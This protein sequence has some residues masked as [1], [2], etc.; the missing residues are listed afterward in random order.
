M[1][2]EK[3]IIYKNK[4]DKKT[5]QGLNI[6]ELINDDTLDLFFKLL[7]GYY[8]IL[9]NEIEDHDFTAAQRTLM[10]FNILYGE[11]TTGGFLELIKNQYCNYIFESIF[12]ET[13]KKWGAIELATII[14]QAREIYISKK[15][16]LETTRS[17]HEIFEMYQYFPEFNAL[18]NEF[19][20]VMNSQADKIKRYIQHHIDEFA[21]V[22]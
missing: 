13:L 22:V 16:E 20:K 5:L 19:F 2:P 9:D 3:D 17:N 8:E 18:D 21:I 11:I 10:A 7:S 15:V 14:D 1:N 6:E 12:S 4:T